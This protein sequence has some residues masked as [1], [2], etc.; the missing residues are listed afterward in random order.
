MNFSR[1]P[2]W[3]TYEV[4]IQHKRE[5]LV[6]LYRSASQSQDCFQMFFNEFEKLLASVTKKR[7]DFTVI[8]GDFNVKP[9]TWG[10]GNITTTKGTNIEPLSSYHGFEQIINE[11]T[12]ILPNSALCIDLIFVDKPNLIVIPY[13]K[14]RHQIIISKLNLDVVYPPPYLHLI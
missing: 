7:F 14:C 6:A 5:F 9:N 1:L 2:E 10:S 13:V 8:V 4:S 3:L 11:S 12:H